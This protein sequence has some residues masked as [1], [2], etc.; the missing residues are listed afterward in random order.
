M[1]FR[2]TNVIAIV[3]CLTA[4]QMSSSARSQSGLEGA[5]PADE[6]AGSRLQNAEFELEK[7]PLDVLLPYVGPKGA[8]D[9]VHLGPVQHDELAARR[10]IQEAAVQL[11]YNRPEALALLDDTMDRYRANWELTLSGVDKLG[12]LYARLDAFHF[13]DYQFK[14]NSEFAMVPI[15]R[16]RSLRPTSPFPHVVRAMMLMNRALTAYSSQPG[17]S[18]DQANTDDP[19]ALLEEMIAGLDRLGPTPGD[20]QADI[21]R[22]RARA[23]LGATD[24]ELLTLIDE[25]SRRNPLA[26]NIYGMGALSLLSVSEDPAG[27]LETVAR[28]AAERTPTEG[29]DTYYVRTYWFV[30]GWIG[31][32]AVRDLKIDWQRFATGSEE[33]VRRFPIQ[34]NIQ[35]LAAIACTGGAKDATRS[36]ISNVK[37]RPITGAWGQIQYFHTCR[38][39]ASSDNRPMS[40]H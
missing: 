36:L 8:A 34:W 4:F 19:K 38:D 30:L 15:E 33:I 39:W 10:A 1:A 23:M 27:F 37:G 28:L 29:K 20:A 5:R 18:S 13:R 22:L 12:V 24:V 9:T 11:R 32:Q 31:N 26:L 3:A 16:W 35:Y 40:K 25:A 17:A 7:S 6:P 14:Q 21:L 2:N